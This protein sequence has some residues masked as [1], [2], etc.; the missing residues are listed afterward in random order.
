MDKRYSL[1]FSMHMALYYWYIVRPEG[2]CLNRLTETK[3][4]SAG[5]VNK[6]MCELSRAE[7]NGRVIFIVNR[8]ESHHHHNTYYIVGR[9]FLKWKKKNYTREKRQ[10][11]HFAYIFMCIKIHNIF[12][13]E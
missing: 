13:D 8:V 6:L 3:G 5:V 2:N 9:F 4:I 10:T 1:N 11:S 7:L 12:D